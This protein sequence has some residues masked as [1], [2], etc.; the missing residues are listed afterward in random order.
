MHCFS[1]LETPIYICISFSIYPNPLFFAPVRFIQIL[2][3]VPL[4][5]PNA[6]GDRYRLY[7]YTFCSV[8]TPI[9]G[10]YSDELCI[11]IELFLKLKP[12]CSIK[13]AQETIYNVTHVIITFIMHAYYLLYT[14]SNESLVHTYLSQTSSIHAKQT[15]VK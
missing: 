2:N 13:E 15:S 3:I 12:A 7:C 10:K 6:L 14:F 11:R 9:C 5:I 1:L 8:F 4:Y